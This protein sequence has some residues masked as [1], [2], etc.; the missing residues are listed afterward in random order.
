MNRIV[1]YVLLF[2]VVAIVVVAGSGLWAYAKLGGFKSVARTFAGTCVM[3]TGP[4]S[5]ED[6]AVDRERG[7]AYLSVLDRAA[8]V[9]GSHVGGGVAVYDLDASLPTFDFS[10]IPE[11]F[12]FRPHG[13]SLYKEPNG[14]RRL[15]V[16]NHRSSGQE[17]VELFNVLGGDTFAHVESFAHPLLAS[18]NDLAVVGPRRFYIANDSGKLSGFE[19]TLDMLFGAG[20]IDLVYVDGDT[21]RTVLEGVPMAAGIAASA[22][23]RQVYV[24]FTTRKTVAVYDRDPAT[25]ELGLRAEVAVDFGVDNIDVAADGALWAAG[26]PSFIAMIQHF[27]SGAAEPS[28][29]AIVRIPIVDGDPGPPETV[30]LD[31]GTEFSTASVAAVTGDTML[32]G[33]ITPKKILR[34]TLPR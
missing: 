5:A 3:V 7:L 20:F 21:A 6:I 18:P 15:Y 25:G 19:R 4:G 11:P 12:D 22:D 29:S 23:A 27:A 32:V 2:V 9:G 33:G 16:I 13:L 28:P 30:Y 26:H 14:D 24:A 1:R 17:T 10:S 31:P 8:L 34:C